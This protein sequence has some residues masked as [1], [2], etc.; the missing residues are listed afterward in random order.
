MLSI[1]VAYDRNKT[2]GKD[3][4][5]PWRIPNDLA[6]FKRLTTGKTVVMGR[7][8][9]KSIGRPLPNRTNIVLSRDKDFEFEGVK[10]LDSLEKIVQLGQGTEDE[11]FIIGGDSIYKQ[12]LPF[13][14]K[15]YITFIDENFDGDTFFPEFES[16]KWKLVSEE[17]G[18][19]NE[20]NPYDYYFRV[21]ELK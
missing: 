17:K 3:N 5:L 14:Q 15:L 7:K 12:A 2:I 11:M 8:T 10:K 1:I 4:R 20:K 6:Y 13:V 19:K 16:S 9:F 18:E 21:Y